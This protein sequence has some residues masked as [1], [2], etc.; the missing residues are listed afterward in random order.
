MR[1]ESQKKEV[2]RFMVEL[3]SIIKKPVKIYFTGGATAVLFGIRKSTI[4]VDIKFEPDESQMYEAIR[5]LK[6]KLDMNIELASPDNFIPPL[7]G[8]RER[9]VFIKKIMNLEFFHYDLSSQIISKVQRGWEQDLADGAGFLKLG[10]EKKNI[11]ALF[12]SIK[13]DFVRYPTVNV[14]ILEQK[15]IKFLC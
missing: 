5:M 10:V 2:E 14:E 9:S 1:A 8:W 7:P 13:N 3:S 11:M 12:K 15:L 4:D 6:E